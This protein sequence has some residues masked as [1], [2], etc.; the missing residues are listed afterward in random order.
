MPSRRVVTGGRV[1]RVPDA[2]KKKLTAMTSVI[3]HRSLNPSR[4]HPRLVAAVARERIG[5]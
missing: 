5:A 3:R 2:M 1:H 4:T